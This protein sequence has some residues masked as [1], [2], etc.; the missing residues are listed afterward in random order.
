MSDSRRPRI[1]WVDTG[2]GIAITLVVLFHA[3]NWIGDAGFAD[4]WWIN[5][6][7]ILATMR[8]PMF[9]IISGLFAGKWMTASWRSLWAT[10]LSLFVWVYVL[11]SVVATFSFMAGLNMQGQQGNYFA[12]LRG[13]TTILWDPRFELWFIWALALFFALARLLNR[14]PPVVMLVTTGIVSAIALT[15]LI[16]LTVGLQGAL[17]YFFFFLV[18]MHL[19]RFFFWWAENLAWPLRIL[20]IGI[21]GALAIVGTRFGLSKDV[22]GYYF[23]ACIAGGLAGIVISDLLARLA[24]LTILTRLGQ[25]TL[26]IYLTHTTIIILICWVLAFTRTDLK[27]TWVALLVPLAL[28]AVAI[29]VSLLINRSVRTRAIWELLYEQPKWFAGGKRSWR[30]QQS[31]VSGA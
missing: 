10:K 16:P 11:W 30:A 26:P 5:T 23:V 28:T 4:E 15:G 6:N 7:A 18:G 25:R 17:K 14:V 3:S 9:F 24:R 27:T 21:A 13:L 2:R 20:V 31:S 29:T 1:G 8:L 19:R 12:Q 22:P